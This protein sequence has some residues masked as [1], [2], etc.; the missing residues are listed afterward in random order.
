MLRDNMGNWFF[1]SKPLSVTK[2][3]K[4]LVDKGLTKMQL[5]KSVLH[6]PYTG[7]KHGHLRHYNSHTRH[8]PNSYNETRNI[9]QHA[10]NETMRGIRRRATQKINKGASAIRSLFSIGGTRKR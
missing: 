7:T 3:I 8:A 9:G 1:N 10:I 2:D 5:P 6:I 4:Q